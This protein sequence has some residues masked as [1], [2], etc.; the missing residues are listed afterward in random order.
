M[1]GN[2]KEFQR[3]GV[4]DAVAMTGRRAALKHGQ[5]PPNEQAA[6]WVG[7]KGRSTAMPVDAPRLFDPANPPRRTSRT[8]QRDD[9][10]EEAKRLNIEF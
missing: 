1:D 4:Y 8:M 10:S 7:Q 5:L 3:R 6:E 9:R 2:S